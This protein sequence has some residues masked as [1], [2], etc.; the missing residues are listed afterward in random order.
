MANEEIRDAGKE[1]ALSKHLLSLKKKVDASNV[2]IEAMIPQVIKIQKCPPYCAGSPSCF[3]GKIQKHT[4]QAQ[5]PLALFTVTTKIKKSLSQSQKLKDYR[6]QVSFF[7]IWWLLDHHFAEDAN[8]NLGHG[9][10]DI[11]KMMDPF[12][13]QIQSTLLR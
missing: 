13:D 5:Y 7:R 10:E 3:A 8:C 4:G 6:S 2:E 1:E 9:L 11:E 12:R